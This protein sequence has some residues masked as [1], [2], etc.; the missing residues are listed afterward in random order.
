M[1]GGHARSI[2]WRSSSNGRNGRCRRMGGMVWAEWVA[3]VVLV[4]ITNLLCLL[5]PLLNSES[6]LSSFRWAQPSKAAAKLA[7]YKKQSR[8][9]WFPKSQKEAEQLERMKE[10]VN[11]LVSVR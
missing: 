4:E 3:A 2:R 1:G 9:G 11:E 5:R 10:V 6:H 7:A 8:T